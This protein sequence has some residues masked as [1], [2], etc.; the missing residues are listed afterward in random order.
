MNRVVAR[1]WATVDL[2]RAEADLGDLLESGHAFEEAP[3]S[4]SLG[5]RCRVGRAAPPERAFVVLLEPDTEGRVAAF[6]A[7]T[8]EGWAATW[9]HAA[10]QVDGGRAGPLGRELLPPGQTPHGPFRLVLTAATIEP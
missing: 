9:T 3:R 7:R 10:G 1:G 8:G 5:A 4:E 6:L 2:E